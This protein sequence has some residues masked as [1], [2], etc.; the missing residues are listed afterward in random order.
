M[1]V[2]D[3]VEKLESG[4]VDP[5]I[6]VV[7]YFINEDNYGEYKEPTVSIERARVIIE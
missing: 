3:L 2:R 6:E 1:K 5:E 7:V 4:D